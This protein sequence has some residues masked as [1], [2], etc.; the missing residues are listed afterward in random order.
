MMTQHTNFKTIS[1]ETQN[2]DFFSNKSFK[3]T[4]ISRDS[5]SLKENN[6]ITSSRALA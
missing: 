5:I 3:K 6:D 2:Y 4:I 1:G